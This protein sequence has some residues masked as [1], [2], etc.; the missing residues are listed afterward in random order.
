MQINLLQFESKFKQITSILNQVIEQ[1]LFSI[2][3][4]GDIEPTSPK[5]N[6][7]LSLHINFHTNKIPTF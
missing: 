6:S 2:L 1:N 4:R 5:F 3:S 7:K